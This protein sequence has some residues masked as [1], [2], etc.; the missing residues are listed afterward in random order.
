MIAVDYSPCDLNDQE[1]KGRKNIPTLALFVSLIVH[2]LILIYITTS[3]NFNNE[4]AKPNKVFN[5]TLKNSSVISPA[6]NTISSNKPISEKS[7]QSSNNIQEIVSDS[8]TP[9]TVEQNIQSHPPNNLLQEESATAV[10]AQLE[11]NPQK[12]INWRADIEQVIQVDVMQQQ[13]NWLEHC[14]QGQCQSLAQQHRLETDDRFGLAKYMIDSGG[15]SRHTQTELLDTVVNHLQT[16]ERLASSNEIDPT[17]VESFSRDIALLKNDS[18]WLDCNNDF[19]S[20]TCAG[21]VDV[22]KLIYLAKDIIEGDD[23]N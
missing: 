19:D 13:Q 4:L 10:A 15:T 22:L 11:D 8:L 14:G 9:S 7:Q 1:T 21:E 2:V 5:I 12:R 3:T 16:L 17:I 20:G 23:N 18:R 6:I